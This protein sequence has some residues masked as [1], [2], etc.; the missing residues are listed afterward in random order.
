LKEAEVTR[1]EQRVENKGISQTVW[2]CDNEVIINI[3]LGRVV[4]VMFDRGIIGTEAT[5]K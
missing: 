1:W 5:T 4:V 3:P 2:D